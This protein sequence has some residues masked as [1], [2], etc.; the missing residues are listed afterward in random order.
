MFCRYACIGVV[1]H[2][3]LSSGRILVIAETIK[4]KPRQRRKV[5]TRCLPLTTSKTTFF[6]AITSYP[7]EHSGAK[8][9]SR[10]STCHPSNLSSERWL[11]WRLPLLWFLPV[12]MVMLQHHLFLVLRSRGGHRHR[13]HVALP[14]PSGW[15]IEANLSHGVDSPAVSSP[16]SIVSV[17]VTAFAATATVPIHAVPGSREAGNRRQGTKRHS[18]SNP[19]HLSANGLSLCRGRIVEGKSMRVHQVPLLPTL[20]WRCH[21]RCRSSYSSL[22]SSRRHDIDVAAHVGLPLPFVLL[23]FLRR[24]LCGRLAVATGVSVS[25]PA[26]L[27]AGCSIIFIVVRR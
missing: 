9:A 14:C 18:S 25:V 13:H 19:P 2:R 20:G 22:L 8:R 3:R 24:P 12:G 5:D 1:V 7:R 4:V 16:P 11:F 23:F 6:I 10:H 21:R 26:L 15:P 27:P 17:V